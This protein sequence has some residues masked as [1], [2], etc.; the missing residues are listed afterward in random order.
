M[1]CLCC[2]ETPTNP[3]KQYQVTFLHLLFSFLSLSE[4]I[5]VFMAC[6]GVLPPYGV[7][8]QK[9]VLI[10]YSDNYLMV[11][12]RMRLCSCSHIKPLALWHAIHK[13][14][15]WLSQPGEVLTS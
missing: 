10:R 6:C 2:V 3:L 4:S 8:S 12:L 14:N 13:C 11:I 1:L 15:C 5:K 9:T 7:Y